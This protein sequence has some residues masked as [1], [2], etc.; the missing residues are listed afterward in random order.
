[1][2]ESSDKAWGV[3]GPAGAKWPV[4]GVFPTREEAEAKARDLG[5]G[6]QVKVGRGKPGSTRFSWTVME[7]PN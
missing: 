5:D 7:N 2:S 1:V 3:I 6:C 4:L